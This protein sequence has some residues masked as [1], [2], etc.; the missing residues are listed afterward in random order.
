[1]QLTWEQ[2]LRA[3]REA[4]LFDGKERKYPEWERLGLDHS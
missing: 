1:M 3:S 2:T 4:F